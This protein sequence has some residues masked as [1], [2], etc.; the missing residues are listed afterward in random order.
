MRGLR[1]LTGV[2][3]AVLPWLSAC[4]FDGDDRQPPMLTT[5]APL[6]NGIVGS[7][8]TPVT[9]TA[10]GSA[11]ISYRVT[12]GLLPPGTSLDAA[13]G[14]YSGTPTAAGSFSFTV[15]AS[16]SKGS[17]SEVVNQTVL[18][19]PMITAPAA[20]LQP[21]TGGDAASSTFVASGSAPVSWSVSAG[22]LPPGM[23]LDASTGVYAGTPSVAGD[24]SFTVTAS[25]AA[26][27]DSDAYTQ[28]VVAPAVNAQALLDD[29]LAAFAT[30]FPAGLEAPVAIAGVNAGDVIV[31]I[32][33]RPQ[34][35]FLYGLGYNA[36]AGT[37]QLYALSGATGQ[38][39]PVGAAGSFVAADGSTP[40]P[41]GAG[42][43]TVF[44]MDF[45]PTV[46]RIRVVNSAGQN[47]RMNPNNGAF[48]DGNTLIPGIN[49]DGGINGAT[50][51]VQETAYTNNS[52][53][54]TV[55]TQYTMDRDLDTLC[56]QN[57]PNAGTQTQCLPLVQRIDAVLG[58][59]I[60]P[61]IDVSA[62]NT[63]AAGSATA[64]VRREGETRE[65]LARI[66]LTTGALTSLGT[67]GSGGVRGLALQRP[68]APAFVG[69]GADGL[70][71]LRFSGTAPGNVVSAAISGV[72]AGE[73][74][75]GIDYRPQ[76]GQLYSLGVNATTDAATLYLLDPQTGS[77]TAVGAPGQIRFVDAAGSAVPLTDPAEGYGFDFNPTV[78][79][80][81]VTSSGGL[82]FR[83]NPNN[84]APVDGNLNL[85][86]SPPDGIN[87]DGALN[88]LPPGATGATGAAYTNSHGQS[89]SGGVTTQYVL[90][91]ESN[92]LFI[93]NPPNAGTVT[94][95]RALTVD[96]D[97][98]EFTGVSGFDI[99][100]Q[101]RVTAS[102]APATGLAF[103]ALMVD[104][105]QRL[106]AIDL[107]N[108]RATDLGAVGAALSG[109]A[110]SQTA[111]R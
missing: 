72:A 31:S 96:G 80:I 101:V 64:V 66:D 69:L 89:L 39:T 50:T 4:D 3:T 28:T 51:S 26:G 98:L 63:P 95:G 67:L 23:T 16:N 93:Q 30:S 68:L 14:V 110:V 10:T 36:A 5:P 38:A 81:R 41:V 8:L 71:L 87:T 46:D 88:G 65:T 104:G 48:V 107:A 47:F 55:T 32:D 77:A 7:A 75:V 12:A 103:A 106:Y 25:N 54:A 56:I 79:R 1:I 45:N 35:G 21:L 6:A 105:G 9:F 100:S 42:P 43:D 97:P 83:V 29:G 108:G 40:V 70:Q 60:P 17:D 33:R 44:G 24:Y 91:A 52:A 82:N 61:G 90:D 34:N 84:G 22:T 92:Q 49:L 86:S 58:F 94:A 62:A 102:G 15:T 109:L 74:L 19:L 57:P 78:D 85:A 27:S 18:Q 53:S 73:V 59:D 76:T 20:P 2:M 11:T 111:V 13:S 99:P 37:V